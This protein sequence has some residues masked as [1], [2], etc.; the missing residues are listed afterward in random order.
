MIRVVPA[1]IH[2]SETDRWSQLFSMLRPR[3][4]AIMNPASGP[5][6]KLDVGWQSIKVGTEARGVLPCAYVATSY[7]RRCW[8]AVDEMVRWRDWYGPMRFFLDEFPS[9]IE[10]LVDNGVG[11]ARVEAAV[12]MARRNASPSWSSSPVMANHVI[13]NPGTVPSSALVDRLPSIGGWVVHEGRDPNGPAIDDIGRPPCPWLRPAQQG[14]LSYN[15]PD[16]ERTMA[17]LVELGWGF[18]WSTS[19]PAPAGNP[20]DLNP[21]T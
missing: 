3:D 5:G 12:L 9:S 10:Q 19:D 6:E 7:G 4:V 17:R 18:G 8:T 21:S 1:Y 15:D 16:P 11:V 13:A 14:W 2:P 20:W